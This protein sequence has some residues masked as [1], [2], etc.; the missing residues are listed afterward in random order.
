MLSVCGTIQE[1]GKWY[2]LQKAE[3]VAVT[4]EEDMQAHFDMVPLLVDKRTDLAAD[5]RAGVV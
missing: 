3:K 2:L 4:A 1:Y 5:K